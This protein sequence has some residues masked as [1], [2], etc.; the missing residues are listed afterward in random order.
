MAFIQET[1]PKIKNIT[2]TIAI[3]I[4]VWILLKEL[5]ATAFGIFLK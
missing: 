3:D 5:T 4:R 1:K 2:A